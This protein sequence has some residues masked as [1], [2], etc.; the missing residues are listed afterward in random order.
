MYC[1][2][3]TTPPRQPSFRAAGALVVAALTATPALA[4]EQLLWGGLKPG[5]HAVGF[6]A[7]ESFPNSRAIHGNL[8]KV[9]VLTGDTEKA[10]AA[11]RR[12]IECITRE[13][14]DAKQKAAWI[15]G[16]EQELKKLGWDE[17]HPGGK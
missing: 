13:E 17:A 15:K 1:Q 12:Q 14:I 2:L 8:A 6:R 3:C 7:A 4:R 16:V 5:P 9:L 11:Y 10:I